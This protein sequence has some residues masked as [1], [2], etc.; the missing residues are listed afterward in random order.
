[1]SFPRKSIECYGV[2]IYLTLCTL[3]VTVV[4]LRAEPVMATLELAQGG[5]LKG[6]VVYE[7]ADEVFVDLGF[8]VLGVPRDEIL[9]ISRAGEIQP[10]AFSGESLYHNGNGAPLQPVRR[11]VEV[12]GEA[13]V[14][15]STPTGL[16]SGFIIHQDGYVVTNDHVVAGEHEIAV[17]VYR[18]EKGGLEKAI[19]E[20][21]RIVATSPAQDLALLKIEDEGAGGFSTVPIGESDGL[22]QGE[23]VFA[24]GSPLGLERSV[25]E[26]I[27]S[28]RNRIIAGRLFIQQTAE[29]SPGNSGGPLFNLRGEVVGVNNMKVVAAG[30]EGLGFAIPSNVLKVFLRNRDAFAFDPQNPNAGFRYYAP[31]TAQPHEEETP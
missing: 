11:L 3:L 23:R 28:L 1:M 5:G 7:R 2:R 15:V 25:S 4:A 26:G 21:V 30:A 22:M 20:N 13:V 24:I 8:Q 31:P 18:R 29:I 9:R 19:Y 10:S 17:T 27:I 12:N 6:P 16:G 14:M